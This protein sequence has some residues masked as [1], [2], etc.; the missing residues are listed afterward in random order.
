MKFPRVRP[1]AQGGWLAVL[2]L[3]LLPAGAFAA[4][5]YGGSTTI[6]YVFQTT[7]D[8]D[9]INRVSLYEYANI[10]AEDFGTPNLSFHFAGWGR[11]D[12]ADPE[13]EDQDQPGDA[14]LT[15]AYVMWTGMDGML[16][17]YLGRHFV[18]AGPTAEI[19]D[20]ADLEFTPMRGL[21]FRGFA[22]VPTYSEAR[23]ARR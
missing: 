10:H 4:D 9:E 7:Y 6:P 16:T 14:D 5:Y 19:L 1:I 22:G 8:G 15:Y 20:G 18:V 12:A 3:L 2:V 13:F 21:S 23:R 17:A 11:W